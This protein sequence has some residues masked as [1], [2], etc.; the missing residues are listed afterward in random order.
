MAPLTQVYDA[1]GQ[2]V[3]L[4]KHLGSGGEGAV[5]E[6]DNALHLVAKLY[7]VPVTPE[8][9]AKLTAM[10]QVANPALSKIAAWP[11]GTLHSR[12]NGQLTGLLMPNV[13]HCRAI[14]E[15]YSPAHRKIAFPTA[16]WAFL[17]HV[18]RNVASALTMIHAQGH[19]V[20]DVNQGNVV[21]APDA[22][23]RLIDCD[24]FQIRVNGQPHLCEVGVAHFTPPEL[25]GRSFRGIERTPNHDNFGLSVLVFHLLFM[26][27]HP[28]AGRFHGRGDMPIEKAV[29]EFHFA[30]SR[31]VPTRQVS[32]PPHSLDLTQISH[33]VAALFEQAFSQQA[34]KGGTRPSAQEWVTALESF[35]RELRTCASSPGHKYFTSL[36]QC[37]WCAIERNGGP[38]FFIAIAVTATV[39]VSS[40]FDLEKAWSA[41]AA[42]SPPEATATPT[43]A[44]SAPIQ[45]TP[46]PLGLNLTPNQVLFSGLGTVVIAIATLTVLPV[47]LAIVISVVWVAFF[48]SA[49]YIQERAKR[50]QALKTAQLALDSVKVRW[51]KE[52]EEQQENF[53]LKRRELER[54]RTEYRE[55]H[56]SYQRDR[57]RLEA[58]QREAQLKG[59]LEQHFIDKYEIPGVGRGRRATLASYGIETAADVTR[60]ALDKVPGFGPVLTNELINWRKRLETQFHFDP[61]KGI[62]P[63]DITA[64]DQRYAWKRVPLERALS[65]GPQDLQR[66]RS[67]ATQQKATRQQ[68]LSQLTHHLA[69]AEADAA[70]LGFNVQPVIISVALVLVLIMRIASEHRLLILLTKVPGPITLQQELEKEIQKPLATAPHLAASPD[71]LA[72]MPTKMSDEGQIAEEKDSWELIRRMIAYAI[73]EGGISHEQEI[74]NT[75]RQIEALTK[76]LPGDRKKARE[77][78]LKGLAHVKNERISEAIV[79]FWEAHRAD[80][81]NVEVV[82]KLGYVYLLSGALES[83][84]YYLRQALVLA[85]GRSSTWA[86]LGKTYAKQGNLPSAIACF[87][88]MYRFSRNKDNTR[89][90]LQKLVTEEGQDPDV[91]EAAR[92]ALQLA[93]LHNDQKQTV[94][95][96][97]DREPESESI[98]QLQQPIPE[99]PSWWYEA[100]KSTPVLDAPR[101]GSSIISELRPGMKVK[102]VG[103]SGDYFI[104]ESVHG[105]PPGYVARSDVAS[106]R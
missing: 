16:D 3:P 15:L 102:V 20:G 58:N 46:L 48:N 90:F 13:G 71:T 76:P 1:R 17:I 98:K 23:V 82:D 50:S 83:A 2:N 4:G 105:S 60:Q 94:P 73:V 57:L 27:R 101:L 106:V 65:S 79:A 8:K 21:V 38:D 54:K 97:Q 61:R 68:E 95:G 34:A 19:V 47:A 67:V 52:A 7:H 87:A 33:A 10:V 40:G 103:R 9:V 49:P 64:L 104:V 41:I 31:V 42:L 91:K 81:T 36:R 75:K 22:T 43:I 86:N 66:L 63:G 32:P 39:R 55:L 74:L 53:S 5:Y 100:I 51:R 62:N 30:F 24:S 12:P 84:E 96:I 25:Q 26:G 18:A 99:S 37:P 88:H 92:Q 56:P 44:P 78:N 93:L 6:V 28:F 11:T 14:H 69:Q 45:G 59:F 77:A 89:S 72:K 85:P 80:K 35:R 29:Q 70:L